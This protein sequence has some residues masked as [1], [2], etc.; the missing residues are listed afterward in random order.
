[1]A[2]SYVSLRTSHLPACLHARSELQ[3][4][5]PVWASVFTLAA[6]QGLISTNFATLVLTGRL[7][8]TVFVT[9]RRKA[10]RRLASATQ[11]ERDPRFV[12]PCRL[13]TLTLLLFHLT[14]ADST[15]RCHL[16]LQ[17]LP[18]C[19]PLKDTAR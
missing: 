16:S 3:A 1:M 7:C 2:A 9:Q 17:T 8:L 14:A 10:G 12:S 18:L 19:E 13:A 15:T 5:C 6:V 11:P 4:A